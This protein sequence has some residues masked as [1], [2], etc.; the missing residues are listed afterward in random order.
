[1]NLKDPRVEPIS[2][3]P[4]DQGRELKVII[5]WGS[6]PNQMVVAAYWWRHWAAREGCWW[7]P[8]YGLINPV[9]W[10]NE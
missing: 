7:S 8:V 9:A 6:V 10:V 5:E 3:A 1:M 2:T 4:R